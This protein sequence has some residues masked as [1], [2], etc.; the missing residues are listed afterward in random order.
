MTYRLARSAVADID[1]IA[2]WIDGR[3]YASALRF[4]EGLHDV[5]QML[6]EN[7]RIGHRRPDLTD[8]SV[9]FW[10]ALRRYAVVY[11]IGPPVMIIHVRD[12]RRDPDTLID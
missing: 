3:N 10:T 2:D 4:V 9:R 6:G 5:F 7:P 11:E 1:D 12:W 8:R